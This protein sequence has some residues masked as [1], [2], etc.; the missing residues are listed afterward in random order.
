M[1]TLQEYILLCLVALFLLASLVERIIIGKMRKEIRCLSDLLEEIPIDKK[2]PNVNEVS[3]D[4]G[5]DVDEY[6]VSTWLSRDES[7][8]K[9][10]VKLEEGKRIEIKPIP[11]TYQ[12]LSDMVA[13]KFKVYA[14][15]KYIA[16]LIYDRT[17]GITSPPEDPPLSP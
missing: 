16:Q 3:A 9:V 2:Y 5:R 11:R 14:P 1:I 15:R 8:D 6:I 10:I 12:D 13:R 17:K 4:L 7:E